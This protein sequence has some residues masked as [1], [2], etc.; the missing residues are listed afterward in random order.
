VISKAKIYI[1]P[2]N[3]EVVVAYFTKKVVEKGRD[4]TPQEMIFRL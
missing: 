1:V 3:E 2:T 4:L